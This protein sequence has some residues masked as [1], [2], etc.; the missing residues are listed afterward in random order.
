MNTGEDL[1]APLPSIS[2]GRISLFNDGVLASSCEIT[3][4]ICPR[5]D[6]N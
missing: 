5:L 2:A 3:V 4:K 1:E 6:S